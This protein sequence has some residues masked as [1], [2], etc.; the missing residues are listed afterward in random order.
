MHPNG[1]WQFPY[2]TKRKA[3]V[4]RDGS[5]GGFFW[6]A[7]E[8]ER[9]VG[10]DGNFPLAGRK[11][12]VRESTGSRGDGRIVAWFEDILHD[13]SK[14]GVIGMGL[15]CETNHDCAITW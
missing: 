1:E 2:L 13:A 3:V 10:L 14:H 11:S 8:G 4:L 5:L 15:L 12:A 7:G 6:Q 9:K